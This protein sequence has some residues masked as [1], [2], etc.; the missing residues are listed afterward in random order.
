VLVSGS[1]G[2]IGTALVNRL[3][4]QGHTVVRLQR[5]PTST[6][7]AGVVTYDPARGLLDRAELEANGPYDA[8]VNLAGAGIGDR[9]WSAARKTEILRSRTSV[10]ALVAGAAASLD[11]RPSA[12]VSASAVGWYGDRGDEELTEDSP[13]GTGFLAEVCQEW[14]HATELAMEAGVRV[15]RVRSGIVLATSGGALARQLP[16]FRLGLGARL[17]SGR[18][19]VS[20]ISL[21][22]EVAVLE[23]TLTDTDLSGPVNAVAPLPVTNAE[24]TGALGR[25]LHRPAI[26][27]VPA[28]ALRLALGHEMADEL[29]LAGQRVVPARLAAVGHSFADPELMGGLTALLARAA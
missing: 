17:G 6:G 25:A 28:G 20:W 8:I 7:T 4:S 22:D 19:H 14:E 29:L 9:R 27:G 18:Q 12:L 1:G 16:L 23:R 15:V 5:S 2:L 11:P 10:T 13:G 3:V 26:L 24:F 21:R